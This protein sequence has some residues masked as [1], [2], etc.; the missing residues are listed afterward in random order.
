MVSH[1]MKM[2]FVGLTNGQVVIWLLCGIAIAFV[3]ARM[4]IRFIY[5]KRLFVDDYFCLL[6]LAILVGN[7]ALVH[8]MAPPMYELLEISAQ[9][10]APGPDFMSRTSFY[11]KAQ[12]ASTVLFWSCLW[13]VKGC[14]LAFFFRLTNQTKWPRVAWWVVTV[15]TILAYIG[16]VVTY[17][18]SCTSFTVGE[19]PSTRG[20]NVITDSIDRRMLDAIEHLSLS[21]QPAIQYCCGYHHRLDE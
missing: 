3:V 12:F 4:A 5:S 6:A 16:S 13:A 14:F 8:F 10:A 11:L 2:T 7:S 15:I 18:V 19:E 17:P 1:A 9:R 20:V 21:R